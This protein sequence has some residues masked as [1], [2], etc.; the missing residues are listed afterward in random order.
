[1][2]ATDSILTNKLEVQCKD[3]KAENVTFFANLH[4]EIGVHNLVYR[5]DCMHQ[6]A[7]GFVLF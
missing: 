7:F 6:C 2:I 4:G 5:A 3:A 1:M